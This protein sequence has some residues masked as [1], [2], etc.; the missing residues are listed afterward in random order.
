MH[1]T[2][3]CILVVCSTVR[4]R[5]RC[6]VDQ[7]EEPLSQ[8]TTTKPN[9]TK[10]STLQ[11]TRSVTLFHFVLEQR[12][13][14]VLSIW[15]VCESQA[16]RSSN[17]E[18]VRTRSEPSAYKDYQKADQVHTRVFCLSARWTLLTSTN[19]VVGLW[20]SFQFFCFFVFSCSTVSE[21]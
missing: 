10:S 5:T 17:D 14:C 9:S 8:R 12:S 7:E 20:S 21:Y 3:A 15:L 1:C 6:G 16:A 4:C 13:Y 19:S 11:E 2:C 18:M